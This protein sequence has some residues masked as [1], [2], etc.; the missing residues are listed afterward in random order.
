MSDSPETQHARAAIQHMM[1]RM[2]GFARGL[3]LDEAA[4]REI[5]ARIAADMPERSDDERL[6][7]A[8]N[9]LLAAASA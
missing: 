2:D 9:C 6:E 4:T 3:G 8:R 5:V 7:T 1:R